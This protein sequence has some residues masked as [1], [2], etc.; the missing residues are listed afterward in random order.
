MD[1]VQ[2]AEVLASVASVPV[3]AVDVHDEDALEWDWNALVSCG[4]SPAWGDVD[5]MLDIYIVTS[6]ETRLPSERELAA[7]L[8]E[9]LTTVVLYHTGLPRP[10]AFWLVTPEGRRTRAR[11]LEEDGEDDDTPSRLLIDAVETPVP[12]LPTVPVALIPE[13]I[14]EHRLSTPIQDGLRSWLATLQVPAEA[15]EALRRAVSRLG[16]WESMT[17]RMTSGWPP[18]GWYPVEYYQEDLECRDELAAA[19][20]RLP[21]TA[22]QRFTDAVNRIDDGFRSVTTKDGARAAALF[23]LDEAELATRSWWWRHLPA[24]QPW[25]HTP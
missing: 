13:V 22:A 11:V 8:A 2:V 6:P 19:V 9:Q 23:G 18:D 1:R 3:N 12:S 25:P 5:W 4:C 17:V 14:R 10:S 20:E 24:P 15:E 7:V 16:A 21:A